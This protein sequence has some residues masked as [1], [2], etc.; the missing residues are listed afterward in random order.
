MKHEPDK[1]SESSGK[2]KDLEKKF[3][4][5]VSAVKKEVSEIDRNT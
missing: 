1:Y 4:G 2:I 5:L 3:K